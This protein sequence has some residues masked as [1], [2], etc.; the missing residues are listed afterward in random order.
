MAINTC[1]I[2]IIFLLSVV[3]RVS[4]Q[5]VS[6]EHYV[7]LAFQNSPLL[8][9]Y[10]NQVVI[11]QVDSLIIR[12]GYKPQVSGTSNN[13]YAPVIHGYGYEGAIT[14]CGVFNTVIGVNKTF[15]SKKNLTAQF[16]TIQL[17]SRG[18]E[19][20]ARVTEQDLRKTIAQQY[21]TAYGD[22]QQL[23]FTTQVNALLQKEE[24][25]LKKLTEKNVYR[26]TDYL[27]FLVTYQQQQLSAKQLA[28]QYRND[29]ATLNYL[30]G[31]VDT[32]TVNLQEPP[33][34]INPL[35]GIENSVFLQQFSID[36]LNIL[37]E[38]LLVD[39]SYQPRVTVF[40]D[41]GFNSTLTYMPYK[42]FG[43]SFGVNLSVPIY[44][45][46]KRKL[47]YGRLSIA[48]RTRTGYRDFT[49]VQYYQQIAQLTQ[50]LRSTEE[51]AVEIN[52]QIK[53]SEALINVNARLLQTGDAKIPDLVI[54]LNNYLAVKNLLTENTVSRLQI[55]SQINYW[56]R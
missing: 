37:N 23:N 36:S 11:G 22:L 5:S 44:D 12:A 53:Y 56:N 45:G 40:G 15:V 16:Q 6:L 13:Y 49:R 4:A 7:E 30:S 50:Q 33:G 48:E 29:I 21:I 55:I 26:Q 25:I 28:I 8:K 54:A 31:I 2:L 14:N 38:R 3:T 18:I 51:L 24:A 35:P 43:V 41:G 42:N 46:R 19:N 9:D 10:R 1:K 39:V 52:N 32:G 20:S 47:Q 17:Q 27:T 34:T